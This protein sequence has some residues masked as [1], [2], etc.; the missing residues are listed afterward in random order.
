MTKVK[1][2]D[3]TQ[4]LHNIG[5]VVMSYQ[6]YRDAY[7][8]A[9]VN[10]IGLAIVTSKLWEDPWAIFNKGRLE[11]GETIED[12]YV[13]IAKP[14]SYNPTEAETKFMKREIPDVRAAF[15]NMNYQK[16]YKV[17]VQEND[18]RL[19]FLSWSG[20]T[21][22]IARITDSLYTGMNYDMYIVRKYMLCRE[23]LNGNMGAYPVY[24]GYSGLIEKARAYSS[25]F[26]FLNE[27]FNR[28]GVYNAVD[29]ENQ[30]IIIDTDTEAAVDV[31]VLASAFNMDR[32]EF[33]GHLKIVDSWTEHDTDR[34]ALLFENDDSY[35]PFTSTD[36]TNLGLVGGV[37]LDERWWF[38]YDKDQEMNQMFNGE[39]RYW[40]YWLHRWCIISVS[41]FHNC[42]AFVT[43][44]GS[45]ST[46]AISPSSANMY[47]GTSMVF[48]ATVTG[49]GIFDSGYEF[50]V[51]S[52]GSGATDLA[53][54]TRIDPQ[55]G[56]L[57]IDPDETNAQLTVTVKSTADPTKTDTATV[58]ITDNQ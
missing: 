56:L 36:I 53:T 33:L 10:R 29:R 54:G 13:N 14:H 22:I 26:G 49:S 8:N 40:Q 32:T 44:A 5:S 25:K 11:F 30:Y 2:Y 24:S 38:V 9:L 35:V 18:L 50:S 19:S 23:I 46:V 16:F 21:D 3:D 58:T 37:L 52:S 42:V 55:S 41:P 20:V 4:S 17:T 15:H 27:S 31:N 45:V 28:A 39:G 6:P 1:V 51:A 34:L 57:F 48:T 43:S 12:I 7:V 47:V